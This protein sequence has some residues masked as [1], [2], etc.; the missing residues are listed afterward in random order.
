MAKKAKADRS[1]PKTN[2]SLAIRMVLEKAP[3][4]KAAEIA[5]AVQEQYGH[6]VTPTLIYLVKS[7]ANV[8][9]SKRARRAKGQT[10]GGSVGGA[11]DWIQA[12]KLAR[13]LLRTTGSVDNAAAI[14]K[15]VDA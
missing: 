10:V 8:K 5:S 1:D 12:I 13:Q 9:A 4:A 15:A 14:L 3:N 7:K 2:K 6:K 11:S